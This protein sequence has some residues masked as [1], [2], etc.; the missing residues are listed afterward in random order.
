MKFGNNN[1]TRIQN[2]N[3]NVVLD[4]T[5]RNVSIEIDINAKDMILVNIIYNYKKIAE[6]GVGMMYLYKTTE[7]NLFIRELESFLIDFAYQ[8]NPKRAIKD[9]I[10]DFELKGLK[11]E[12]DHPNYDTAV[13]EYVEGKFREFIKQKIQLFLEFRKN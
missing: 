12:K 1:K 13:C 9:Y 7:Y 6:F 10:K 2:Y 11:L 4:W 3:Q 5:M 8:V